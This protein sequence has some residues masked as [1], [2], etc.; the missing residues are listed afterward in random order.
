MPKETILKRCVQFFK[1]LSPVYRILGP[2]IMIS[3][4][5]IFLSTYGF[6]T[7]D[8]RD[9]LYVIFG[10]VVL[11]IAIIWFAISE[12]RRV[13]IAKM[14]SIAIQEKLGNEIAALKSKLK[15]FEE[16]QK[17]KLKISC[18]MAIDGCFKQ[19]QI[20][21]R[22]YA[23]S[24]PIEFLHGVYFRVIVEVDG[25]RAEAI[26]ECRGELLQIEK[27]SS[28]ILSG[29]NIVLPFSPSLANS[30]DSVS[31][32][33]QDKIPAYLEILFITDQGTIKIP[34]RTQP[35]S[36]NIETIFSDFG[37]YI[38]KVVVRGKDTAPVFFSLLF[39]WKGHW[40]TSGLKKID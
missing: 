39:N 3:V 1:R 9:Y 22:I 12:E 31:K 19:G 7:Q 25:D 40:Q 30:P 23:H 20:A 35:Y 6:I 10:Y 37:E 15:E 32:T 29:E 4:F 2:G 36:T 28:V 5:L 13:K 38:L 18:D 33:I 27:G 26:N 17:P 21:H 14:E 8:A 24:H 34:F 16:N 11:L